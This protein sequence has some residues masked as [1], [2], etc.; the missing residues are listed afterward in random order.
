LSPVIFEIILTPYN[1]QT[2]TITSKNNNNIKNKKR[3]ENFKSQTIS[4]LKKKEINS[5]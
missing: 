1:A 3:I 5:N 2:H 4:N